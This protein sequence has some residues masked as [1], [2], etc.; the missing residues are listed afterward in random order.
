MLQELLNSANSYFFGGA[1]SQYTGLPICPSVWQFQ[2]AL[3]SRMTEEKNPYQT[4]ADTNK[5]N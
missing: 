4:K 1:A 5:I 2:L 3:S